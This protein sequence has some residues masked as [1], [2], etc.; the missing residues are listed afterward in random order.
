ML[1]YSLKTKATAGYLIDTLKPGCMGDLG[2]VESNFT[3]YEMKRKIK[4]DKN[5]NAKKSTIELIL[6]FVCLTSF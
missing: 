1:K 6:Q 4:C 3:F 2:E 5:A